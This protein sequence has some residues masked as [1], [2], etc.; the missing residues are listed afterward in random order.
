MPK[1]ASSRTVWLLIGLLLLILIVAFSPPVARLRQRAGAGS[2]EAGAERHHGGSDAALGE[3]AEQLE[4][5]PAP[6]RVPLLLKHLDAPSPGLRYA[7]VDALGDERDSVAAEAIERAFT[8]SSSVV[9][10]RALE[11]LPDVNASRGLRLLLAG[12]RDEDVWIRHAAATQLL[13][14]AGRKPAIV[15]RRA[16]VPV[17]VRALDDPDPVVRTMA[18]NTLRKLTGRPWYA[19]QNAPEEQ[20]RAVRQQWRNWWQNARQTWPDPPPA[21]AAAATVPIRPSR[22]DPAPDFQLTDLDG[23]AIRRGDQRGRI[24]LLNFW[25]TWCPPCRQEIPDLVKLDAAY[26]GRGV[27]LIG[28]AVAERQGADGLRRWC[29]A[30][31]VSYRQALAT[32]QILK[33]F[34]DIEAVPVSVLIDDR[35]RIRYRWEGE[36]PF[37]TFR[38]AVEHLLNE[39]QSASS[40]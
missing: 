39:R 2:S 22:T 25:G 24:T 21:L 14:R 17:L 26:R 40:P 8:D 13:L 19:R 37:A 29:R 12:L 5:T 15:D 27:D 7:A 16:A 36:R 6:Q 35:G 23:R 32:D 18:T 9:R 33:A 28:V 34:D 4:R 38:A 10:Q 20:K 3:V 31:K 30:Q 1:P 11:V